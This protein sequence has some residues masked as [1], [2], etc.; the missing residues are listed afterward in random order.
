MYLV[1]AFNL[2]L[3]GWEWLFV[4]ARSRNEARDRFTAWFL[5]SYGKEPVCLEAYEKDEALSLGLDDEYQDAE[6]HATLGY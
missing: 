6:D 4:E 3:H 2:N 5:K 1:G